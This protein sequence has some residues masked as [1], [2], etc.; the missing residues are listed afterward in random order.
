[1]ADS[2]IL[3]ETRQFERRAVVLE[4]DRPIGLFHE[5]ELLPRGLRLG[6]V[7]TAVLR[8]QPSALDGGFCKTQG[9]EDVYVR[10]SKGATPPLG[11]RLTVEIVAE[12]QGGKAARGRPVGGE[13][14]DSE[15]D[16]FQAWCNRFS[17]ETDVQKAHGTDAQAR[18]D[19]AFEQALSREITLP[20]GGQL[21]LARTPALTAVDIDTSGRV[22]RAGRSALA[23]VVN[24]EAAAET[25]RQLALRGL[26]GLVVLDC[27]APVSKA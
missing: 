14:D 26:G 27:V 2:Q 19:L 5:S 24:L 15:A 1:M 12:A 7:H 16:P 11:Q 22:E 8:A 17:E 6:T 4:G 23:R 10:F 9:G 25:A 21:R 13:T 20:G 3:V 18:I